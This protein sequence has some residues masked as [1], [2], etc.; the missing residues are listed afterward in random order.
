M[1]RA[2][3]AAALALLVMGCDLFSGDPDRVIA[4]EIVGGLTYSIAVNDTL[5]LHARAV[6]ANGDT[7]IDATIEWAMLDTGIVHIALEPT[8][9]TVVG[10]SAGASRVQA[11]VED[12]R[13]DAITI[14]VTAPPP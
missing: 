12:I 4:L 11:K 2:C 3:R 10:L 5:G 13:S 9:G 14:T 6:A 7:V 1:T 8:T